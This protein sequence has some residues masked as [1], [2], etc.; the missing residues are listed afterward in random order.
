MERILF[1][2]LVGFFT[3]LGMVSAAE[4]A[5]SGIFRGGWRWPRLSLLPVSGEDGDIEQ[6]LRCAW[7]SLRYDRWLPGGELIIVNLGAHPDTWAVCRA[8]ARGR[9]GVRLCDEEAL[10]GM[11]EQQAVYKGVVRILY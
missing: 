11:L 6:R 4:W 10:S 8:F 9:V 3:L 2:L 1:E 7:G 5:M